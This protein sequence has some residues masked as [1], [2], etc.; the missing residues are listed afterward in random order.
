MRYVVAVARERNFTR[1]AEHLH[2][3][4][5]ALS[6]QVRAVEKMLGLPLFERDTRQVKLTPAGAVFVEEAKRVLVASER[7]IERTN[8]AARGEVGKVRLAHTFAIANE[9]L[10]ALLEAFAQD[11]PRVQVASREMYGADMLHDLREDKLDLALT[12]RLDLDEDLASEAVRCEQLVAA[13]PDGHRLAS[14]SQLDLAKLRDEVFQTWPAHL[15]P[16][17]H[18]ATIAACH[19]AGFDP[20]IDDT[21][22][23][24]AAFRNI[25][26]GNGVAL[27]VASSAP[28]L[29]R[30][31]VLVPLA[32]PGAQI[33]LDV[34]W[35]R[36]PEL[37]AVRRFVQTARRVSEQRHWL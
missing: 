14:E 2:V 32:S 24:S 20:K 28:L 22:T 36:D 21:A 29:P 5:Q 6:Q 35:R 33:F 30:G 17:Y 4:Q 8:A 3:A 31:I 12:P 27:A 16:G 25:A 18:A 15:S 34:L 9:T 19:A 1:A 23:G 7:A 37:P 10:P 26:A 11:T 13:L